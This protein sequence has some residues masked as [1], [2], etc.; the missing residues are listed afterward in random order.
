MPTGM[1]GL[2]SDG[3]GVVPFAGGRPS[4][5]VWP[6]HPAKKSAEERSKAK[7]IVLISMIN[8]QVAY[9]LNRARCQ[10]QTGFLILP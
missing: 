6:Q 9:D 10:E 3:V 8:F 1:G 5:A 7:T 4:S 2:L